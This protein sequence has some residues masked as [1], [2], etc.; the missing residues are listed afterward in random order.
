[1]DFGENARMIQGGFGGLDQGMEVRRQE[2]KKEEEKKRPLSEY[3]RHVAEHVHRLVF[4]NEPVDQIIASY[5]GGGGGGGGG[6]QPALQGGRGMMP[7]PYPPPQP[8]GPGMAPSTLN[9]P[10]APPQPMVRGSAPEDQRDFMRAQMGMGGPPGGAP[11]GPMPAY[12]SPNAPPPPSPSSQLQGGLQQGPVMG[13]AQ[14][15]PPPRVGPDGRQ[16]PAPQTREDFDA[17]MN[18]VHSGVPGAMMQQQNVER[19][20]SSVE[21]ENSL[22]RNSRERIATAA[23]DTKTTEGAANRE[24]QATEGEKNRRAKAEETTKRLEFYKQKH[25]DDMNLGQKKIDA[26]LQRA[27]IMANTSLQKGG[28]EELKSLDKELDR[29]SRQEIAGQKAN[30]SV[31]EKEAD[32]MSDPAEKAQLKAQVAEGKAKL[33]ASEQKYAEV[34]A[35]RQEALKRV[36]AKATSGGKSTTTKV[37]AGSPGAAEAMI[38][39]IRKSDGVVGTIPA[40]NFDETKYKKAE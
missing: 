26:S 22:N 20:L 30:V 40:A 25:A 16:P 24:S 13:A 18:F 11:Q 29:I 15:A 12:N 23:N 32:L 31:L 39:V 8:Q 38:K 6:L 14:S 3:E 10:G 36:R 34:D 7:A 27:S 21:Q 1:M 17:L 28:D 35:T 2:R 5:K 9:Q 33:A 37:T 19:R 4:G